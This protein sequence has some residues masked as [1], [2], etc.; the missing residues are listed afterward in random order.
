MGG[1]AGICTGL[2]H[3][4][5]YRFTATWQLAIG[6]VQRKRSGMAPWLDAI[7]KD[8]KKPGFLREPSDGG[9]GNGQSVGEASVSDRLIQI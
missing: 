3:P 7:G 6:C 8:S 4:W 1:D 9:Q 5:D 2:A